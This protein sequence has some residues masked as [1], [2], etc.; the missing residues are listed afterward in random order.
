MH[1]LAAGRFALPERLCNLVV[2][3]IEDLMQQE[4]GALFRAEPLEQ[5]EKRDRQVARQIDFTIRRGVG[6]RS[7]SGSQGPE[8]TLR[9]TPIARRRSIAKRVAVV[10]SQ[11]H[12]KVLAMLLKRSRPRR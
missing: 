12:D 8:Y 7:G 2:A 1:N 10:T 4:R 11:G 6:V 9:S 3:A 5:D